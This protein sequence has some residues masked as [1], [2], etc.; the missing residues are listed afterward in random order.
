MAEGILLQ[1][2]QGQP[3]AHVRIIAWPKEV[4]EIKGSDVVTDWKE[5]DG[6][7]PAATTAPA[8]MGG[9]FGSY[10]TMENMEVTYADFCGIGVMYENCWSLKQWQDKTGNDKHSI[11]AEPRFKDAAKYDF[12]PAD[13]SPAISE[14]Q[15]QFL[16]ATLTCR[17]KVM[18]CTPGCRTGHTSHRRCGLEFP[19][20]RRDA[21][22]GDPGRA[23][24]Q[25]VG[26]PRFSTDSGAVR[27]GCHGGHKNGPVS[28]S[29]PSTVAQGCYAAV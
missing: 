11:V 20:G 27:I 21:P 24:R 14:K 8:G 13:K 29:A 15:P 26:W 10:D 7:T 1:G 9:S 28:A 23:Q 18:A 12:H 3:G 25:A 5:Y 22:R 19:A 16:G 17:R 2:Y 4:V 6:G